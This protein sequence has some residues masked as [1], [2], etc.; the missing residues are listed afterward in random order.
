MVKYNV[1][2]L[3]NRIV[4][5]NGVKALLLHTTNWE[6]LAGHAGQGQTQH[7][8]WYTAPFT[9]KVRKQADQ[10]TM[11]EM[12]RAGTFWGAKLMSGKVHGEST[13]AGYNLRSLFENPSS[14]PMIYVHFHLY[15]FL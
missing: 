9:C 12:W 3:Y 7:S 15:A 10:S 8:A 2:C 13:G 5:G 4:F 1:V 6:Q 11:L 14:C